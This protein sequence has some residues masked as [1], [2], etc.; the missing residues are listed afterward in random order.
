MPLVGCVG[1]LLLGPCLLQCGGGWLTAF[2][3]CDPD[4]GELLGRTT[5]E[6]DVRR[7]AVRSGEAAVGN[8]VVDAIFDAAVADC[9]GGEGCPVAAVENSGGIRA[10]TSCGER[11][12][13]PV[14]YIH[15]ADVADL[16]PFV[17]NQLAVVDVTGEELWLMLERSV[18]VL[19]QVGESGAAGY[20]LQV[21]AISFEVDCSRAAQTLSLGADRILNRGSRVDPARVTIAGQPLRLD[22]TY[23]I[24]MN[25]FVATARD[26]FLAL[27]ERNADD[28]VRKDDQ[29]KFITKPRTYVTVN[30]QRLHEADALRRFIRNRG[31]VAPRVEGRIRVKDSCIPLQ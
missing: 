8:L 10:T 13:I 3:E 30:G 2:N 1:L 12:S 27:A 5:V 26:G 28:S 17:I 18:S 4:K 22:A 21:H 6:M 9:G 24:A 29:G 16:L 11:K 23:K 31:I 20:F 7:V 15:D 25:D 14:G 19:G